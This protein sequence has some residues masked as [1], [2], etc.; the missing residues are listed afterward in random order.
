MRVLK[1]YV[2]KDININIFEFNLKYLIKFEFQ[3]MEQTYKVDVLEVSSVDDIIGK[4]DSSF[5]DKIKENFKVM[6]GQLLKLY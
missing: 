6:K 1:S 3:D 5:I 4:I 2:I